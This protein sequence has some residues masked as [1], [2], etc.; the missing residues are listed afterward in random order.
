MLVS[1]FAR[2]PEHPNPNAP[3]PMYNKPMTSQSQGTAQMGYRAFFGP[4]LVGGDV[5]NPDDREAEVID[6]SQAYR[7]NIKYVSKIIIREMTASDTFWVTEILP[8]LENNQ[9]N[10]IGWNTVKFNDE[11]L[12]RR[13]DEAVS[14]LVSSERSSQTAAM[15]SYGKAV[16]V[17]VG[18]YKT[19][20][21]QMYWFMHL[22][23]IANATRETAC[24]GVSLEL[25]T[26]KPIPSNPLNNLFVRDSPAQIRARMECEIKMFGIFHEPNGVLAAIQTGRDMLAH[27]SVVPTH[28]ILPN[29]GLKQAAALAQDLGGSISVGGLRTHESRGFRINRNSSPIDPFFRETEIGSFFHMWSGYTRDT[30]KVG[31]S[32][33]DLLLWSEESNNFERVTMESLLPHTMLWDRTHAQLTDTG[34]AFFAEQNDEDQPDDADDL[35]KEEIRTWRQFL[36]ADEWRNWILEACMCL[37]L[38]TEADLVQKLHGVTNRI[39]VAGHYCATGN[40]RRVGAQYDAA[41]G[42]LRNWLSMFPKLNDENYMGALQSL[43]NVGTDGQPVELGNE[44]AVS[45]RNVIAGVAMIVICSVMKNLGAGSV[46]D[47]MDAAYASI[48]E[49]VG[50]D[51]GNLVR[52]FANLCMRLSGNNGLTGLRTG[53]YSKTLGADFNYNVAY[54]E[55]K[56]EADNDYAEG[57]SEALAGFSQF[58]VTALLSINNTPPNSISV[59]ARSLIAEDDGDEDKRPFPMDRDDGPPPGG[60]PDL[61]DI[62]KQLAQHTQTLADLTSGKVTKDD[63]KDLRQQILNQGALV[64]RL[65]NE[66]R[67]LQANTTQAAPAGGGG[68]GNDTL[69][70]LDGSL[71]N[72]P[73]NIDLPWLCT[74]LKIAPPVDLLLFMPHQV[75]ETGSMWMGNTKGLGNTFYGHSKFMTSVDPQHYLI[76]GHFVTKLKAKVIAP[77]AMTVVPNVMVKGYLQGLNPLRVFDSKRTTVTD[78]KKG[79]THGKSLFVC[80]VRR[81]WRPD[82]N[83]L[84]LTGMLP[85]PLPDDGVYQSEGWWPRYKAYM[86]YWGWKEPVDP[87][88][89]DYFSHNHGPHNVVCY[90]GFQ[91]SPVDIGEGQIKWGHTVI[92]CGHLGNPYPGCASVRSGRKAFYREVDYDHTK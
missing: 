54:D 7:G 38:A 77:E 8:W 73:I 67:R 6:L 15:V 28:V 33:R 23:Q 78:Y 16:M 11:I 2:A 39:R 20:E 40:G 60:Q 13:P 46:N 64:Q 29:G 45:A 62:T 48:V 50:R 49:I 24:F 85:W 37:G 27:E 63:V 57:V 14:R 21:G 47:V 55:I 25:L 70:T 35:D 9:S 84:S 42:G 5:F 59:Y 83:A 91:Q 41:T 65:E 68:G 76:K 61:D 22:K 43:A 75:F 26:C 36:G 19:Q 18:F 56:R 1:Q 12:D 69:P 52:R 31:L 87:T 34:T 72:V 79:V 51:D 88:H 30:Q 90:R 80:V 58:F 66:L 53:L 44:N 81:G 89:Q 82:S 4:P 3:A 17:E 10:M 74:Q 71:N 32:H 92:N 86:D